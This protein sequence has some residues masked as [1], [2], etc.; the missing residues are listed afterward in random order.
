MCCTLEFV[1]C[2]QDQD[3]DTEIRRLVKQSVSADGSV[4]REAQVSRTTSRVE[5]DWQIA[6]KLSQKKYFNSLRKTLPGSG[7]QVVQETDSELVMRRVLPG[8]AYEVR[9]T[10]SAISGQQLPINVH[11]VATPRLIIS[12][13]LSA[14]SCGGTGIEVNHGCSSRRNLHKISPGLLPNPLARLLGEVIVR[15]WGQPMRL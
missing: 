7:Y 10:P 13:G 2:R 1:A 3:V 6:T 14:P 15:Q 8:D 12:K 5:A 11:F 9:I 4:I